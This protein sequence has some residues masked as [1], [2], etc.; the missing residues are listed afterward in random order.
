[1]TSQLVIGL[2]CSVGLLVLIFLRIPIAVAMILSA[3][4]GI[5]LVQGE[6]AAWFQLA[7]APVNVTIYGLSVIPLFILMGN[8][9]TSA[10]LSRDLFL[11]TS[12]VV[13]RLPGGLSIAT[14]LACAGFSTL[15]GSSLATA[16]TIGRI[17][18]GEMVSRGYSPALA[19]GTVAAGGTIGILIPPSVLLV[20]YGL[21][22][23]QSIRDLFAAGVFPGLVLTLMFILTTLFWVRVDPKVA[24]RLLEAAASVAVPKSGVLGLVALVVVVLG[25]LY[26]GYFTATESASIGV[27]GTLVIAVLRKGLTLRTLLAAL[28]DT[29]STSAMIFFIIIG[30][31]LYATFLSVTGISGSLRDF[32][33]G[34]D[35]APIY[36]LL[37]IL[38]VY[39]ILGC[40]MDSM[41]MI[42]LTI[43]IFYPLV[44]ALGYDPIV[45]GV[46]VV[47]VVEVG[48]ITPPLG[49]N[50]FV[51]RSVA[52]DI[53][54]QTIFAGAMPFLMA[55]LL[56][57]AAVIIW[58]QLALWLPGLLR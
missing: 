4:V 13:G 10:G 56:T 58:P 14:I 55:F 17:S 33:I 42:L 52:P 30:S 44:L 50:I 57:V 48:L 20:V 32:V 19:A 7:G 39:V 9:A 23:E 5:Y 26:A 21:L 6:F 27:L 45:F 40:V 49:M 43:P 11:L 37:I 35:V 25:G 34:L 41:G 46:L 28:T 47:M 24:P 2:W 51:V 36:V 3:V 29:A 8:L 38:A 18:L 1:M 22:T 15:S 31:A 12:R 16:A 53:P 54:L